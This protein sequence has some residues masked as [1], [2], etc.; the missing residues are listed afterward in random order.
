MSKRFLPALA[1]LVISIVISILSYA[2]VTDS[3]TQYAVL[4]PLNQTLEE[5]VSSAVSAGTPVV[6]VGAWNKILIVKKESDKS[7]KNLYA[8][9]AMA[10][11]NP[12]ILGDC[13]AYTPLRPPK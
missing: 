8:S 10:V 7:I 5:N 9:G 4:F 3:D 13:T 6:R 2:R 1:L 12:A 11:F